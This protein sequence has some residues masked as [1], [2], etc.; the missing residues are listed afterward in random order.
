MKTSFGHL[1]YCS[2]IHPGENWEQHFETLKTSIPFIK[3][4]VCPN[5][6]MG[7]GLRLA[8][9]ASKLLMNEAYMAEFKSWLAANNCYVFTM[10]G[11]PYG[12]FHN[13]VVKDQVHSPDW[14]SDERL[15]YTIR[16]FH[17]LA[18]LLPGHLQ[19]GGISTSPLSYRF[20]WP[21]K[22]KTEQAIIQ[23]TENIVLLLVELVDLAK[24]TGKTMHLDLEPEPG[25]SIENGTEF[26][27]WYKN[28]LIPIAVNHFATLGINPEKAIKYTRRHIQ[29]CYDVCHFAV[30]FEEPK[31]FLKQLFEAE[32]Q[33][34]KIQISSAL[35]VDF[36]TDEESKIIELAK[37]N[38]ATY[39]HQVIALRLDG[40]FES[41]PDLEVALNSFKTNTY[42][43]WRIHFH[44][45]LFMEQFGLLAS[46]QTEIVKTLTAQ[47]ID[48][49]TNHLEIET[50]TW[51]V[52]PPDLQVP[53]NESIVRELRWVQQHLES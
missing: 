42:S 41:F 9:E 24:N 29:L 47:K 48:P 46:T 43:E 25:G 1:T 26:I 5:A 17:I 38:E 35:K 52:L 18:K 44:V 12:G 34:G 13:V 15:S 50:Y 51:A 36:A 22:E 28:Y 31:V 45:P 6:P 19:E 8:N 4:E 21:S 53:L 2:N 20:W 10:N 14:T 32:I 16:L 30:S 3:Q 27:D 7:I 40:S 11:F 37:F 49:F 39:L 23:A 33:V